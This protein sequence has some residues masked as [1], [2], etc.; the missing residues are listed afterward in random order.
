MISGLLVKSGFLTGWVAPLGHLS[1]ER[2]RFFILAL[3]H[4]IFALKT[5]SSV[6]GEVYGLSRVLDS[7]SRRLLRETAVRNYT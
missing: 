2:L 3:F 5:S 4:F 1:F 7:V 6:T